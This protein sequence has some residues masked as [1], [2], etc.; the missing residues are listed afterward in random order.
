MELNMKFQEMEK[1]DEFQ[2]TNTKQIKNVG[3]YG[4]RLKGMALKIMEEND[5]NKRREIILAGHAD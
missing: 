2:M 4:Y 3:L 1:S 5:K